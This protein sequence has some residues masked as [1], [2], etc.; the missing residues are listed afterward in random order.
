MKLCPICKIPL[1]RWPKN[2]KCV[3]RKTK[4]W[5]RVKRKPSKK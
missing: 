4:K 1:N 5:K 2:W 3:K